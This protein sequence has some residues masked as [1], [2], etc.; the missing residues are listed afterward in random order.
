MRGITRLERDAGVLVLAAMGIAGFAVALTAQS[1]ETTDLDAFMAR[2]LE[3]R[4]ES[5]KTLQQYILDE[6][7]EVRIVGPDDLPI[8]GSRREYTWFPRDGVF[9]R[10]PV[11]VD[12]VT[13]DEGT[14]RRAEAEWLQ[15]ED[16]RA[17]RRAGE[18]AGAGAEPPE[19]GPPADVVRQSIEPGFVSAAYFLRFRFDPGQYA[20]V[21]QETLDGHEVFRIEYYPTR[22]FRERPPE[23]RGRGGGARREREP[24]PR[25]ADQMNRTSLVTLWI[26]PGAHQILQYEFENVDLDFLPGR[27]FI[28]LDGLEASMRMH[29][30]FPGVWLPQSVGMRFDLVTA[31]G[32]VVG[33]Y[34]VRY[35]DYRLAE[36]TTRIR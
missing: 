10:S 32:P 13:L 24:D 21:G 17:R 16:E 15:R 3:R 1:Q 33:E 4:A 28:R 5:W 30:P 25:L 35:L 2:V 20:L 7:E 11:R 18:P 34:R 29:E 19:A 27:T 22:L 31:L 14:R 9:V 36:V 23:G 8:Y 26:E 6:R 12:G